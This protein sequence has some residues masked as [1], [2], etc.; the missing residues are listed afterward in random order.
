MI[1]PSPCSHCGRTRLSTGLCPHCEHIYCVSCGVYMKL[2]E[3]PDHVWFHR[4][5]HLEHPR[6]AGLLF[7]WQVTMKLPRRCSQCGFI[8]N[9]DGDCPQFLEKIVNGVGCAAAPP[10]LREDW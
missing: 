3:F 9:A 10:S 8:L 7:W 5:W 2:V 4:I 6:R 1:Q